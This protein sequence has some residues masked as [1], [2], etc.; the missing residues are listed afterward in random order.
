M[1]R[2]SFGMI[3]TA[4]LMST[5]GKLITAFGVGAITYTGLSV[6]QQRFVST[7]LQNWQSLPS[8]AIQV[9]LIGGVGVALNWV[10][11]AIAFIVTY[12]SAAKFGIL[13]KGKS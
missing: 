1:S 4:A 2:A 3:I 13:M 12:K 10:F 6:I 7:A 8:D 11:G 5:A 9:L